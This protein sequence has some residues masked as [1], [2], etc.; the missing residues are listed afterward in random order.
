MIDAVYC[1]VQHTNLRLSEPTSQ[2]SG[3][4]YAS[5]KSKGKS[6]RIAES[7]ENE[8]KDTHITPHHRTAQEVLMVIQRDLNASSS[9]DASQR[10]SALESIISALFSQVDMCASEC[11]Q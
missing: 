6:K 4:S 2:S 1:T 11:I 5:A 10:R 7:K 8:P 9:D 3:S